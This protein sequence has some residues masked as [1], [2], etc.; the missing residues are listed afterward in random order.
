V[1]TQQEIV[2]SE[3]RFRLL[4]ENA[5]DAVFVHTSRHFA[6]LNSAAVRLFGAESADQLIGRPVLER[7]HPDDHDAVGERMRQLIE[8]KLPVPSRQEICLRMDGTPVHIEA[9]AIVMNYGGR[10][11][12]LV[13]ARDISDRIRAEEEQKKLHDQLVQAQKMES[14]GR[15]AGG[16]AHDYNNFLSV[17]IGY[18]ELSMM[19]LDGGDPLYNNLRQVLDAANR[20]KA[21]TRQLL[22]FARKEEISPEVLD[23]N[24]TVES[25][26]KMIRRLIGE[27]IELAWQP[28]A[29]LWPV[30]MDPSQVDQILANLCINARDAIEHA[31]RIVIESGK[32]SLDEAFCT[33]HPGCTQGDFTVLAVSDNGSGMDEETLEHLFEP[34]YT[35]KGIDRGTGLGLSTVYGIVKQNNGFIAVDSEI[36]KGSRFTVYLPR[37]FGEVGEGE[38]AADQEVLSGR[39]EKIMVVEDEPIILEMAEKIL[40]RFG[41]ETL[42]AATPVRA[43][44]M[45]GAQDEEIDLLI[46][47]V[48]MPEMNGRELVEQLKTLFPKIRYLYMSGYTA[49]VIAHSG[50]LERG[51]RFIQKPFSPIDLVR[52]VREVIFGVEC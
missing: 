35:T 7:F 20:S 15:L 46:T 34:F 9:S 12:A 19:S 22:A 21:L 47:D 8:E 29:R 39:G 4:V 52:K 49:D 23:L 37:Y 45:A 40:Q 48:I 50:V 30:E 10:D 43:L 44:E 5:P 3:E 31:G 33:Q 25:M 1:H 6:Y 26:L 36:G 14:V 38:K 41:Y 11:G 28:G 18:T 51:V 17:I 42:T 13:F 24:T 16:V 2:A 27:D 32:T